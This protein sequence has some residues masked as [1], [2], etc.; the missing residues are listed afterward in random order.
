MPHCVN[1]WIGIV[2][3]WAFSVNA[4][5]AKIEL[6]GRVPSSLNVTGSSSTDQNRLHLQN[7]SPIKQSFKIEMKH[8]SRTIHL[9]QGQLEEVEVSGNYFEVASP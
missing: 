1:F 6:M 9:H 4:G 8:E 3:L 2:L 7:N 5:K